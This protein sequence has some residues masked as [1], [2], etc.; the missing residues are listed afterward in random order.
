VVVD[1]ACEADQDV[2]VRLPL[3]G[4][5]RVARVRAV[6][7]WVRGSRGNRAIGLELRDPPEDIADAIRAYVKL[8]TVER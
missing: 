7:K 6:T 2:E 8:M 4:S 3:P 1:A 5:G